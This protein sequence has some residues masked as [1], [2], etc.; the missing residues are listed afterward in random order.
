[1]TEPFRDPP[2]KPSAELTRLASAGRAARSS[3]QDAAVGDARAAGDRH[4]HEALAA[5]HG[6]PRNQARK[7]GAG[8]CLMVALVMMLAHESVP[9]PIGVA[10]LALG[11]VLAVAGG[12][13]SP[14]VSDAALEEERKWTRSLPFALDGYFEVL[15]A[16]PRAEG[17]VRAHI[18]WSEDTRAVDEALLADAFAAVDPVARLDQADETGVVFASGPIR[19]ETGAR[20]N[21]EPV[22]RNHAYPAYVRDLVTKVL[23]PLA[24]SYP[25]IRVR[26]EAV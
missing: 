24:K 19:G 5:T 18:T 13:M 9:A 10:T 6:A 3:A 1:V 2:D 22:L 7:L 25:M 20:I 15:S 16:K 14:R 11:I 26:L 21:R 17:G 23:V 4:L 8:A 12:V